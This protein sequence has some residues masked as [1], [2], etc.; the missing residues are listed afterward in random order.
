MRDLASAECDDP[1]ERSVA[2]GRKT[3][4][5][6]GLMQ[7]MPPNI[8]RIFQFAARALTRAASC[9]QGLASLGPEVDYVLHTANPRLPIE[10]S[11][12][13]LAEYAQLKGVNIAR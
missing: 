7:N 3:Y 11:V 2:Q 4:D 5:D 13:G 6:P 12:E 10:Q 8:S 9:A 1:V